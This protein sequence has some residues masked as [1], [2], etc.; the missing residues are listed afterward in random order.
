MLD[1]H[2]H[3][4]DSMVKELK[5]ASL[6]QTPNYEHDITVDTR[7]GPPYTSDLEL[8]FS[9]HN[10]MYRGAQLEALW[11]GRPIGR[12]SRVTACHSEMYGTL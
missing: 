2:M 7:I 5:P 9:Q 11:E 8:L 4:S 12:E 1:Q 10:G 6:G 3:P